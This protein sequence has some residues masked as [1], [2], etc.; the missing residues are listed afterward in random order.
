VRQRVG[1][2]VRRGI[3][4]TVNP[5]VTEIALDPAAHL[6]SGVD[7]TLQAPFGPLRL[8]AVHL[9]QGC[10]YFTPGRAVNATCDTLMAQFDVVSKWIAKRRDE[11]TPFLVLGDFNRG[12]ERRDAF[13]DRL[14]SA[15]P[16]ARADE[17]YSSPCWNAHEP[18]ID[19]ILSG[20]P[21]RDW[22]KPNSFRV[23]TYQETEPAWKERLS[24]HC[25]V[26]VR[27]TVPD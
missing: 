11:A 21:A 3:S 22:T 4:Y 27:L 26:S 2:V 12:L 15:E 6:R 23:L 19:H 18:F 20:G 14:M 1:I 8:L 25:P 17:G 7:I 10:Q 9:K 13:V 5:D 24:D 16:L